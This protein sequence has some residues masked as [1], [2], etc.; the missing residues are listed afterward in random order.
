MASA[1]RNAMRML[2]LDLAT[3]ARMASLHPACFLGLERTHG[4]IAPGLR[5]NLV[6]V[7]TEIRAQRTWIDGEES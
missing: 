5:A 1:V 7:D 6:A 3:A 4:R 2:G